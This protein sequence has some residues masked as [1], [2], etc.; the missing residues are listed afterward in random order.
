MTDEVF[1]QA[2]TIRQIAQTIV[3]RTCA[4]LRACHP[5]EETVDFGEKLIR[6]NLPNSWIEYRDQC[7]EIRN[8]HTEE[9]AA[10]LRYIDQLKETVR[11]LH[12]SNM[13]LRLYADPRR[14]PMKVLGDQSLT[15]AVSEGKL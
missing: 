13:E 10:A 7:L 5:V 11:S 1:K 9:L 6:H 8:E 3:E 12:E 2:L 4:Q 14:L 15:T